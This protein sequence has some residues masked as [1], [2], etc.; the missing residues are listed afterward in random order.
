VVSFFGNGGAAPSP[1]RAGFGAMPAPDLAHYLPL[2]RYLHHLVQRQS[3]DPLVT[4]R[5]KMLKIYIPSILS[6]EIDHWCG[7]ISLAAGVP[8]SCGKDHLGHYVN[9]PSAEWATPLTAAVADLCESVLP[10]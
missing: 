4:R 1:V 2:A 7:S 6:G 9:A 8:L 10:N 5:A 3:I